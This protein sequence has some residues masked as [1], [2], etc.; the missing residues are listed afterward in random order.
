MDKRH[1]RGKKEDKMKI[2]KTLKIRF[3][4]LLGVFILFV[5]GAL[6]LFSLYQM[7]HL[8]SGTFA[9][10]GRKLVERSASLIDVEA[11]ARLTQSK[12]Q[13]DPAYISMQAALLSLKENFG[14][15]YLYT[16]VPDSSN[17]A[18]ITFIVDG[19]GPVGSED[20]SPAG[21][22][23]EMEDPAFIRCVE[24]KSV[25]S[26]EPT[27]QG[28]WGW[29]LSTYAPIMDANGQLLGVIGADF[30]ADD[31]ITEI[32]ANTMRQ[33]LMGIVLVAAGIALLIVF[34]RMIFTPLGKVN[35]ALKDISEGE[36][37]LRRTVEVKSDNEIGELAHYFN[38]TLH[39]IKD[40]LV[41]IK[42]Q[43]ASLSGT[44]DLL[45]QNMN[46]TA[47]AVTE[48]TANIQSVQSQVQNQAGG[49]SKTSAAME[50][51]SQNIE[52]LN[53]L[54]TEQAGKIGDSAAAIEEMLAN[55]QSVTKTLEKNSGNVA[56]LSKAA[57]DG[58]ESLARVSADIVEIEKESAG[59]L[60]INAVMENIA[61]QT[62]LLSMNAAIEAAHA[63]ES[64]KGFAV[65]AGEIRKLAEGS[66]SQSKTISDVLKKI[67]ISI[68]KVTN[69]TN[70]VLE[71]F[72]TIE[73]FV[74]TV[75]QEINAIQTAMEEQSSGSQ[76][77]LQA[78]SDLNALT[79]EV[80]NA[81]GEMLEGSRHVIAES[82]NLEAVTAEITNGMNEMRLGA[83]QVDKSVSEVSSMSGDNKSGI[84][85]LMEEV[86]KFIIE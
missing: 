53:A 75:S 66:A 1:H 72:A 31:L 18:H 77:I 2:L 74:Q 83:A 38:S 16:A 42:T 43:A 23:D 11:F 20:F 41:G 65:V 56:S 22:T 17:P 28:E 46:Q 19:S 73:S 49:V 8:A 30:N 64:G 37:D 36:G 14:A 52:R 79:Q 71:K 47:S 55:I 24:S 54:M 21:A 59:L 84:G 7:R 4:L 25:V 60:E 86:S 85:A 81:S 3:A 15:E 51:M 58:R 13:N 82:K 67:K 27:D 29:L 48:I 62:N 70:G 32:Q 76:G 45:E 34:L 44:G 6:S 50:M 57:Q 35:A 68:D 10:I 26:G 63:G 69:G 61:S 12:D 78:T 40:M 33:L 39:K 5:C 80:R 9:N